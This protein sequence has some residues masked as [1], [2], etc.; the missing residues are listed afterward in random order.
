MH[1]RFTSVVVLIFIGFFGLTVPAAKAQY[2]SACERLWIERNTIYKRRGYC[3][4]T[5]RAIATFG[6]AGCLHDDVEDVPLSPRER[7]RVAEIVRL[8]RQFGCR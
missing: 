5:Q 8:E 4:N 1:L 3:F 6:N 2:G 7:A